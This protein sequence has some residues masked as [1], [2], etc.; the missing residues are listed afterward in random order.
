M[1]AAAYNSYAGRGTIPMDNH[2]PDDPVAMYILE[3]SKVETLTK[4]EE[5]KL[6]R[7]IG[8]W[9]NWDEQGENAAR[10]LVESQLI[11]VVSLTQQHSAA[12]VPMLDIMQ[13]GNIGLMNAVRS[14]AQWPVGD[15]SA[16][17]AACIEDPI[18]RCLGESKSHSL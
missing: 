14:F 2:D 7:E 9:G 11:L 8:R 17:A 5:T 6:F 16:H 13:E 12:G 1:T 18:K 3:A 15:F 10:R 4:V